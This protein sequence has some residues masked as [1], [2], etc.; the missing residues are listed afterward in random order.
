MSTL[1]ARAVAAA[2]TVGVVALPVTVAPDARAVFS[3]SVPAPASPPI[4]SFATERAAGS[5]GIAKFGA[6][7]KNKK[8]A[9]VVILLDESGSLKDSDPAG[10]RVDASKY[11]VKQWAALARENKVKMAI[12]SMGFSGSVADASGAWRD[13][14]TD[15]RR[16]T[17]ELEAF[18]P[19]DTG[20]Q[21]DY[22][23]ALDGARSALAERSESGGSSCQAILWF[24]DGKLD[25]FS[26]YQGVV[27]GKVKEAVKPYLK[28]KTDNASATAA[29]IKD[30]CRKGG[31]ADQVRSSGVATFGIGLAA[32]TATAQDLDL[33]K[34][35]ALG[36][37]NCGAVSAAG[38]GDFHL[39][40]DI[41][42]LMLA[43]DALRTPGQL[44][45]T[46][47]RK[48]CQGQ[49]CATE[50]HSFVLDDS[51]T[52]VHVAATGGATGLDL[53]VLPPKGDAVKIPIAGTKDTRV[54]GAVIRSEGLAEDTVTLDFSA[55]GSWTGLWSLVFVDPKSGSGNAVSETSISLSGDI[56]PTATL[57]AGT[58]YAGERSKPIQLGLQRTDGKPI[59]PKSLL[60]SV[61][62]DVAFTDSAKNVTPVAS[63][64]DAAGLAQPVTID[65]TKAADGAGTLTVEATI[66]TASIK[67]AKGKTIPGTPLA[68]SA[69]DVD[70]AVAPPV[71]FPT[72]TDTV[73][74]GSARGAAKSS[75]SVTVTGPGCV[76]VDGPQVTAAPEQAGEIAVS[77]SASS[78]TSCIAVADGETKELPIDFATSAAANGA[79]T[80]TLTAHLA[81]KD[82]P[83]RA[84]TKSLTFTANLAKQPDIGKRW[85]VFVATLFGGIA[86]PVGL[87]YLVKRMSSKIPPLPLMAGVFDVSVDAGQ[88]LRDGTP[89]ALQPHELRDPIPIPS[90]GATSLT[91]GPAQLKVS[92]GWSPFGAGSVR[93]AIAGAVG[94]SSERSAVRKDGQAELPL[95]IHNTWALFTAPD[96]GPGHGR[97]L[98]LASADAGPDRR[99][100]LVNKALAIIPQRLQEMSASAGAA[101]GA[102]PS[103][104]PGDLGTQGGTAGPVLADPDATWSPGATGRLDSVSGDREW[105]SP[106]YA[107]GGLADPWG[108]GAATPQPSGS[109]DPW[110]QMGGAAPAYEPP[111]EV[112]PQ[113]GAPATDAESIETQPRANIAEQTGFF[114]WSPETTSPWP[115][116]DNSSR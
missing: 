116:D 31:L 58:I 1:I 30:L 71:G 41:G 53:Y 83:D 107:P 26:T 66:T 112:I 20:A 15:E 85:A 80:G 100:D 74:F 69:V 89:F 94:V 4:R 96:R 70:V 18:R 76:W 115:P 37:N 106:T 44:P 9:D 38:T 13:A 88:V 14:A 56:E 51:I 47:R 103:P 19:R 65:L 11:L 108:Q 97:L 99:S 82:E 46:E 72:V 114:D 29:A 28:A 23:M 55:K 102:V 95:A 16:I 73:T 25:A 5:Q 98:L 79:V 92:N 33:M 109:A 39:A 110:A 2:F 81:P 6:C 62:V 113:T 87:M 54:G 32:K 36:T 34:S 64:I 90:E 52:S 93:A 48:V 91:I 8:S 17:E 3:A 49:V 22:W 63:G 10:A 59:D 21:T 42:Q 77:S 7:M 68:T 75:A 67:P 40:S 24:S 57:P 27:N 43:F 111:T 78:A 101:S 35:I 84:R 105:G 104:F 50:A 45:I 60:G 86:I 61:V 12:Q